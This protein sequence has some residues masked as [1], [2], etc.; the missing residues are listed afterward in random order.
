MQNGSANST[1]GNRSFIG[2]YTDPE[3]KEQAAQ[4]AKEE[5]VSLSEWM[6]RRLREAGINRR[7]RVAAA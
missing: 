2:F 4:Q 6:R 3:L 1:D 5:G 7:D